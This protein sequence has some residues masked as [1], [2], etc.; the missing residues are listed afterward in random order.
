MATE[1]PTEK[2]TGEVKEEEINIDTNELNAE[3]PTEV[4]PFP[5]D[6]LVI[7]LSDFVKQLGQMQWID[8]NVADA[9]GEISKSI[10]V[11]RMLTTGEKQMF[12]LTIEEKK[13]L[14]FK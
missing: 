12:K 4:A 3:Q 6:T 13:E 1:K 14:T 5:Y 2:P 8:D 9:E 10:S 11:V 7:S